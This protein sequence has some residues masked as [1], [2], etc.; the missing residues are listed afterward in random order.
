MSRFSEA[1][2]RIRFEKHMTQEEFAAL[3]GTTKQNISRYEQG[4]VSPK[5]STAQA[6]ADKLGI[7]LAELNGEEEPPRP[8]RPLPS[9]VHTPDTMHFQRV[10][11]IGAVAAGK[12]VYAPED[13]GVYV[14]SPV[15]CD[16]AVDVRGDSMIP[17]Y[18]DGDVVYVRQQPDVLDG[19]VAIVFLDDEAV[20]KR[21][22]HD[23]DGLT[24]LSD[25]PTYEPIRATSAEYD[26]ISVFGVP[27]GFTRMY[28]TDPLNKI[29]KGFKR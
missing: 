1:L 15:K 20:I 29:H 28:K 17:G 8:A 19:Q 26:Y 10:P 27:V 5:I 4:T 16:A 24:L 18:L 3:L 6:I 21:V 9:N 14:N 11:K 22:Y 12:P 25:N 23:P 13:Y 2:R 7:T